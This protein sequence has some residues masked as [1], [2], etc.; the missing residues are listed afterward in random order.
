MNRADSLVIGEAELK[1][2][3]EHIRQALKMNGDPDWMLGT[4]EPRL[5]DQTALTGEEQEEEKEAEDDRVFTTTMAVI[6]LLVAGTT[7]KRYVRRIFEQLRRLCKTY[8]ILTT[9]FKLVNMLRQL[10]VQGQGGYAEGGMTSVSQ[11]M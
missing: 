9:Y 6:A 3:K 8:D 2:E 5:A 4:S 11:T 1:K 7:K 10:L